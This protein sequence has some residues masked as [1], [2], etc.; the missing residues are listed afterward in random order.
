MCV[1]L[2]EPLSI[3]LASEYPSYIDFNYIF[4]VLCVLQILNYG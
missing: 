3:S 4:F 1:T 2:K